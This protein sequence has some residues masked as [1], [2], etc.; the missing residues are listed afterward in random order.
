MHGD[1]HGFS[2]VSNF[3]N[4]SGVPKTIIMNFE[5]IEL[6]INQWLALDPDSTKKL[7]SMNG[8]VVRLI[9]LG[10][11]IQC[12]VLIEQAR[13]ALRSECETLPDV[14][15]RGAPLALLRMLRTDDPVD[16]IHSGDIEISGNIQLAG[17]LKSVF[18]EMDIDWEELFAKCAGDIPAHYIGSFVRRMVDWRGRVHESFAAST[19]EYLKEEVRYLPTRIEV[20]NFLDDID[21]A[22]ENLDRLEARVNNILNTKKTK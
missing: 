21:E 14:T 5:P 6:L 12:C 10:T 7:E 2:V 13:F 3:Q 9:V 18:K 15:I 11:G 1:S 16:A 22:R 17:K 19:G 4:K 20:N 8:M